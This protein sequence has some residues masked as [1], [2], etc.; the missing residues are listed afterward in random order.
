MF[1]LL[2]KCKL[3]VAKQLE[4]WLT[5]EVLPSLRRTGE[6]SVDP[7]KP[8]KIGDEGKQ[9]LEEALL[10]AQVECL[11]EDLIS[12]R[13]ANRKARPGAG[14]QE[15]NGCVRVRMHPRCHPGWSRVSSNRLPPC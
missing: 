4:R 10:Q 9:A 15:R 7:Q 13:I 14:S 3:P 8:Q 5:G 1:Q 12:K 11:H 2:L 6:Y